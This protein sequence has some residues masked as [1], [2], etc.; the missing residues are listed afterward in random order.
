MKKSNK[1]NLVAVGGIEPPLTLVHSA[2]RHHNEILPYLPL[3]T[4]TALCG[5]VIPPFLFASFALG[6]LQKPLVSLPTSERLLL[7]WLLKS[8]LP[9]ISRCCWRW[10]LC[11]VGAIVRCLSTAAH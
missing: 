9:N 8:L 3:Q 7:L 4:F 11:A 10:V 1:K 6:R 5:G 2:M